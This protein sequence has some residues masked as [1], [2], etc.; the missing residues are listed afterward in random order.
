MVGQLAWTCKEPLR[1]PVQYRAPSW[2]WA[3]TDAAIK[4]SPTVLPE[5]C[6]FHLDPV[7]ISTIRVKAKVVHFQTVHAGL[8]NTRDIFSGHI[9]IEG[10]VNKIMVRQE[11]KNQV[12]YLGRERLAMD[13][14]LDE[15]LDKFSSL[16]NDVEMYALPLFS[17]IACDADCDYPVTRY[18]KTYVYLVLVLEDH[19]LCHCTR[20]GLGRRFVEKETGYSRNP[21]SADVLMWKT[22]VPEDRSNG[23]DFVI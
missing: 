16:D 1:R 13:I 4:L 7:L 14:D 20:S 6:Y 9:E 3:S 12:A 5:S 23:T 15:P 18:V 8:N 21:N 22:V 10:P 2:S 19:K 11:K 17:Y